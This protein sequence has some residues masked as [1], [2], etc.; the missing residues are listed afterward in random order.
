[1]KKQAHA[2]SNQMHTMKIP[3]VRMH[4][5]A[6]MSKDSVSINLDCYIQATNVIVGNGYQQ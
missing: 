4:I 2:V 6:A 5:F 3:N 1:M